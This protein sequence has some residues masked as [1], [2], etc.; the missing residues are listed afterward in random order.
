MSDLNQSKET[1]MVLDPQGGRLLRRLQG[2]ISIVL[3]GRC[4]RGWLHAH[5]LNHVL[6]MQRL[7]DIRWALWN[8][9]QMWCALRG[10]LLPSYPRG[11]SYVL[12][13]LKCRACCD[14]P[15][16]PSPHE[17]EVKS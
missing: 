15:N 11:Y 14:R 13:C 17:T 5:R 12:L 3:A 16:G 7:N 10:H 6:T 8:W 9:R 4:L 1:K 2:W